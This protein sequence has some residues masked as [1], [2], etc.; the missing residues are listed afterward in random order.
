M[1]VIVTL[2]LFCTFFVQVVSC[3]GLALTSMPLLVVAGLSLNRGL[4]LTVKPISY[5]CLRKKS[6][7]LSIYG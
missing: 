4:E 7:T 1:L 6:D 3:F 2:I 5:Q